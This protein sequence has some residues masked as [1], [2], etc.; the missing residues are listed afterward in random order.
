MQYS[1]YNTL[2]AVCT[3]CSAG[4][5]Y[6]VQH[7]RKMSESSA[8]HSRALPLSARSK[9]NMIV[10]LLAMWLWCLPSTIGGREI[11]ISFIL[12]LI[13]RVPN[14]QFP[15]ILF[16]DFIFL[17][18]HTADYQVKCFLRSMPLPGF[19]QPFPGQ[20][21]SLGLEQPASRK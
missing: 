14:P 2:C 20:S 21:Q 12:H 3:A 19:S 15:P 1:T 6:T 18:S 4:N 10:L 16:L 8:Q 5:C 7:R 9:W 11:Y 13:I 17:W